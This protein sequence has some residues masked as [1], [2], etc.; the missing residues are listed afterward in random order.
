[1]PKIR[2]PHPR[3]YLTKGFLMLEVALPKPPNEKRGKRKSWSLDQT[4]QK[5]DWHRF[6]ISKDATFY[7]LPPPLGLLLL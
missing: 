2:T 5:S 3:L 6:Q 7:L 4:I 1:M